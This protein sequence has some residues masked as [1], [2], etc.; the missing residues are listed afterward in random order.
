MLLLFFFVVAVFLYVFFCLFQI[1]HDVAK[2][3]M[4]IEDVIVIENEGVE[5][6]ENEDEDEN[7]VGEAKSR[8]KKAR[9]TK[10]KCWEYFTVVEVVDKVKGHKKGQM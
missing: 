2:A 4:T 3:N 1:E 6:E 9:A 8:V 5:E 10:A 7:S